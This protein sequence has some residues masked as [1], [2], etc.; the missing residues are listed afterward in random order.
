MTNCKGPPNPFM[1][2]LDYVFSGGAGSAAKG[3]GSL[4]AISVLEMPET[5]AILEAG[6]LPSPM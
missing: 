3:A 5:A 1:G 2:T 4:E 6:F